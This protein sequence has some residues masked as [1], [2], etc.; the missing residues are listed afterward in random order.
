MPGGEFNAVFGTPAPIE[1]ES[2]VEPSLR[3]SPFFHGT[4]TN[5]MITVAE[6]P[7]DV[8]SLAVTN[9]A[10]VDAYLQITGKALFTLGTTAPEHQVCVRANSQLDLALG[11][12]TIEG[13]RLAIAST[14]TPGGATGAPVAVSMTT[15]PTAA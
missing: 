11:G 6:A 5:A 12:M 15:R 1:V 9:A 4:V 3:T 7:S 13:V 14:T 2:V 8:F 10:S